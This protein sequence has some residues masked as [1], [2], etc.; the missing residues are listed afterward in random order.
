MSSVIAAAVA[1]SGAAIGME[2]PPCL[3]WSFLRS[4][5]RSDRL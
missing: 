2:Q 3:D 4:R 5:G 1:V